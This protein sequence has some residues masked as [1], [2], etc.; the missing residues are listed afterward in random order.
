MGR[1]TDLDGRS[2]FL[3][4]GGDGTIDFVQGRIDYLLRARVVNTGGGRAG[5]EMV[6]LNGVTVPV[7]VNGPFNGVPWQVR[8]STVTAGMVVRSVPNVALGALGATGSVMRGKSAS[9]PTLPSA[10]QAL[11]LSIQSFA[12]LIALP[13]NACA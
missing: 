1:N 10:T 12:R 2:D 7:E 4:V 5:P 6:F 9:V 8:W 13:R 3:N 11:R